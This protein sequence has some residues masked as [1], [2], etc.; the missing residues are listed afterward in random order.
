LR[1]ENAPVWAFL[2]NCAE[3]GGEAAVWEQSEQ[4]TILLISTKL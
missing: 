1:E 2:A 3:P 4:T